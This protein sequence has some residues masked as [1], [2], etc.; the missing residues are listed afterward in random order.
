MGGIS[1][2]VEKAR[3]TRDMVHATWRYQIFGPPT[4]EQL[5][6]YL[7]SLCELIPGLCDLTVPVDWDKFPPDP[8]ELATLVTVA[9]LIGTEGYPNPDGTGPDPDGPFGPIIHDVLVA[10]SAGQLASTMADRALASELQLAA[11]RAAQVQM[12]RLQA[13]ISG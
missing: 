3:T 1:G 5:D 7:V 8:R 13:V 10:L 6:Q 4:R 9:G 2:K 12:G 11:G